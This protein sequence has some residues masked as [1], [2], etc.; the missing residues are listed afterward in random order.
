MAITFNPARRA[1]VVSLG[2]LALATATTGV[3]T[4]TAAHAAEHGTNVAS[5][6]TI[7]SSDVEVDTVMEA[8]TPEVHYWCP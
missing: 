4:L 2:S 5:W 6:C 3:G 8:H 7:E 1:C